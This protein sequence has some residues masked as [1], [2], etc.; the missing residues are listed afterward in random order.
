MANPHSAISPSSA[1]RWFNCP[2]SLREV[3]KCPPQPPS[4]Y[5]QEGSRAHRFAELALR[6][7]PEIPESP[8]MA[9]AI[10]VYLDVIDEDLIKYGLSRKDLLIEHKFI[11]KNIHKDAYGTCDAVLP[12]F[13]TKAIVYDF[14]YGSGVAVD[15]EDNKQGLYYALGASQAGDYTDFEIVIV[16]PR[17]IHKQGPIRRWSVTKAELDGFAD[18]LKR[19][20]A[21]ATEPTAPLHA[22]LWCK[23]TFCPA[24]VCCPAIRHDM[25]RAAMVAFDEPVENKL[26]KPESLTPLMLRRL[27]DNIPL[28]DTFIKAVEAYALT[29]ANKGEEVLGYKLVA[30]KSNRKWKDEDAVV[31]KFGKGVA[32]KVITEVLSP[33]QLEAKLKESMKLK[34][35][36]AAVEPLTFKPDTGNVLVPESDPRD[37]VQPRLE[38]T[39]GDESLFQ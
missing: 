16:Q 24:V 38:Q 39:F 19:S 1:E 37:A 21:A 18:E 15:A 3:A 4:E 11:L 33:S 35:A 26:P 12:V 7:T 29:M 8:E 9:E 14:K 6:G 23:K 32:T 31:K 36:K 34:E 2:G 28:I 20:I 13:L 27:L 30:R 22:G 5:A 17:A 10:Q 25:E